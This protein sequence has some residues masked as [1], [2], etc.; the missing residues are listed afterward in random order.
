M[1]EPVVNH[2]AQYD[3]VR[4]AGSISFGP[5]A[6][7]LAFF[8]KYYRRTL[9]I[10]GVDAQTNSHTV[11]IVHNWSGRNSEGY[12][13]LSVMRAAHY[14]PTLPVPYLSFGGFSFTAG[15]TRHT[16]IDRAKLL[17]AIAVPATK[18]W[19]PDERIIGV[20]DWDALES[21]RAATAERP[22]VAPEMLPAD[23]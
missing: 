10:N 9:V 5:F 1:G 16:R 22:A 20:E 12:P 4:Q 17:R 14:S 11:G 19:N 18:I 13:T 21:Y 15:I 7:N 23:A 8:E 6:N 2:W 3:E